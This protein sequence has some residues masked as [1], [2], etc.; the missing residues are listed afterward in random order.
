MQKI[1]RKALAYF[2]TL[3]FILLAGLVIFIVP[4]TKEVSETEEPTERKAVSETTKRIPE[5]VAD[6]KKEPTI[7]LKFCSAQQNKFGSTDLVLENGSS[8]DLSGTVSFESTGPD[9][10][11]KTNKSLTASRE[12]DLW[13]PGEACFFRFGSSEFVRYAQACSVTVK[14]KTFTFDLTTADGSPQTT[15][16][17]TAKP[18]VIYI[19]GWHLSQKADSSTEK[20]WLKEIFPDHEIECYKWDSIPPASVDID[21]IFGKFYVNAKEEEPQRLANYLIENYWQDL[22]HLI[23]VGH[24]LGGVIA[25]NTVKILARNGRRIDRAILLGTALPADDEAL[26]YILYTGTHN[27]CINIYKENDG[28]LQDFQGWRYGN[29]GPILGLHGYTKLYDKSKLQQIKSQNFCEE[30][31]CGSVGRTVSCREHGCGHY[32]LPLIDFWKLKNKLA[33]NH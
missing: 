14:G 12:V 16:A 2:L 10:D 30:Y 28:W 21:E 31:G 25:V 7:A 4:G 22:D 33:D 19:H 27:P 5:K 32:M 20:N 11:L 1:T 15:T 3:S 24:S 13:K 6:K 8:I 17:T 23:L 26:N 18:R 9:E 29:G